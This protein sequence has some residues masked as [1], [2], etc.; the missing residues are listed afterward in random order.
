MA[1]EDFRGLLTD[2][3]DDHDLVVVACPPVLDVAETR[4]VAAAC[5]GAVLVASQRTSRRDSTVQA[6]QVLREAG[7]RLLGVALRRS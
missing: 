1:G 3:A 5:T 7:A 2:T 4:A 6:A